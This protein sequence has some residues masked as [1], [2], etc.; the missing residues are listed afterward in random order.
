[1]PDERI[2]EYLDRIDEADD[3]E[4]EEA[5]DDHLPYSFDEWNAIRLN[6]GRNPVSFPDYVSGYLAEHSARMDVRYWNTLVMFGAVD[7]PENGEMQL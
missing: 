7:A 2:D 3:E 5:G 6:T 1:M 4:E